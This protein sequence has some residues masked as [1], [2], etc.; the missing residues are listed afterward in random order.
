MDTGNDSLVTQEVGEEKGESNDDQNGISVPLLCVYMREADL[1]LNPD[2]IHLPR[3]S[4]PPL[5][6]RSL[7]SFFPQE[8][9]KKPHLVR[10]KWEDV[11]KDKAQGGCINKCP[12]CN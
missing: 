6:G 9:I 10:V 8:G 1:D 3:V 2:S 4:F 12:T 7:A 11:S 5:P